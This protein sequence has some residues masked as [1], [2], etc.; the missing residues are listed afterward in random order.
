MLPHA[1]ITVLK[2]PVNTH[3]ISRERSRI[4]ILKFLHLKTDRAVKQREKK[5]IPKAMQCRNKVLAFYVRFMLIHFNNPRGLRSGFYI[6]LSQC[7]EALKI[8]IF[9][10]CLDRQTIFLDIICKIIAIIQG[11]WDCLTFAEF[12]ESSHL[13]LFLFFLLFQCWILIKPKMNPCYSCLQNKL[14]L[15]SLHSHTNQGEGS[16]FDYKV[17]F[18]KRKPPN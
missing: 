2:A 14:S 13:F 5:G 7:F 11:L 12:L 3:H 6:H 1:R 10:P 18:L 15:M 9:T 4:H 17:P 16:V 8:K